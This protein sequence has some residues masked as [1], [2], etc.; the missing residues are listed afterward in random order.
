MYIVC[1]TILHGKDLSPNID[2][3]LAG[4]SFIFKVYRIYS[5]K[6]SWGPI[7]ADERLFA[8][9]RPVKQVRLYSG[10]DRMRP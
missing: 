4:S 7:I 5:G 6:F 10:H 9:I 8:K 3:N 1:A 2:I